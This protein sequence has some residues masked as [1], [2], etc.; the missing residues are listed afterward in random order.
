MRGIIA[1]LAFALLCVA[2]QASAQA[3]APAPPSPAPAPVQGQPT[4]QEKIDAMLQEEEQVLE[5]SGFTY[6]PGTRRDPFKSLMAGQEKPLLKGPRPEGIPGLM[7]DE[8]DL[9]GIFKTWKGY[10]AQV[11]ASNKGKSYLLREGDQLYDGDV[12]SIGDTE[13]VFKQIVNDPTALKPF[14]E[15]VK[16]LTP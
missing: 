5:G 2:P 7:I 8:V 10:V 11:Q 6:D 1:V 3:P 12:V 9:T 14:R 15:V 4:D 16:K 13:V